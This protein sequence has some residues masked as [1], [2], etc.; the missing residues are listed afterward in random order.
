MPGEWDAEAAKDHL[1]DLST[2]NGIEVSWISNWQEAMAFVP[3]RLVYIPYPETALEHLVGLHE[4]G[5][6]LGPVEPDEADEGRAWLWAT[7][8]AAAR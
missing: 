4:M 8:T 5:H 2:V 7:R 3:A 6:I 1:L